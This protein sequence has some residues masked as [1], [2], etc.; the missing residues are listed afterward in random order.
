MMAFL[1]HDSSSW[2]QA[3]NGKTIKLYQICCH[4]S[5]EKKILQSAID[6]E[7]DIFSDLVAH[8]DCN[9]IPDEASRVQMSRQ[10]RGRREEIIVDKREL[11]AKLPPALFWANFKLRSATLKVRQ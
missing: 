7:T 6:R 4:D 5:V 10:E 1:A 2:M 3:E 11:R 8:K 9:P